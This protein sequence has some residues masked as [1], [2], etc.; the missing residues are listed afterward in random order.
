MRWIAKPS[1]IPLMKWACFLRRRR[2]LKKTRIGRPSLLPHVDIA[3]LRGLS[4]HPTP[5]YLEE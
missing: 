2:L 1:I 5:I 3:K 4:H